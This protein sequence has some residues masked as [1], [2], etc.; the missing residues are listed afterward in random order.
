MRGGRRQDFGVDEERSNV[1]ARKEKNKK[2]RASAKLRGE[3]DKVM[4]K[5][6]GGLV[7]V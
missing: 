5:S 1:G 7:Q 4:E 2:R 3:G 6:G